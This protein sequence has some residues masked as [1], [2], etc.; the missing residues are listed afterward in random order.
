MVHTGSIYKHQNC[1]TCMN[2][3][4]YSFK[5]TQFSL[6]KSKVIY[7]FLMIFIQLYIIKVKILIPY[8]LFS[9]LFVT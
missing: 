2:K 3:N 5:N 1:E 4:Q 6:C 8:D 9:R 7:I